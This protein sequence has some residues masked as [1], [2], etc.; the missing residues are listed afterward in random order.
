MWGGMKG[1]AYHACSVLSALV[2]FSW[3]S[4]LVLS[5][6]LAIAVLFGIAN[7]AWANPLHARYDPHA[8][9]YIE[10]T[11]SRTSG[12]LRGIFAHSEGKQSAV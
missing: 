12:V 10:D 2:A 8:S 3:L 9:V 5:A 11:G 6:L 1:C 4:W 7:K